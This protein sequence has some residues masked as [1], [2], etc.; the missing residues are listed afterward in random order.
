[1]TPKPISVADP[2]A[3]G[4]D[5]A[6]R[7]VIITLDGHV[8]GA[9]AAA[10]QRLARELP[11]LELTVHAATD[12][13]RDPVA[14]GRCLGDIAAADIVFAGMLFLEDHILPVLPALQARR[15]HCDAMVCAMSGAE[16]VR[17]TKLGKFDM[18][19]KTSG[20]MSL[21]KRLR[22]SRK[23]QGESSGA[24]QMAMLRRLP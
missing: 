20:A 5:V 19:A 2:A 12:W 15:D 4:G 18:S 23:T 1:M 11:G 10:R 22:G 8:A 14:L 6:V 9:V 17:L 24:K 21:L 3:R 16:I 13:D 7:M